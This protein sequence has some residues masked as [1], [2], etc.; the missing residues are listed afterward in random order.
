MVAETVCCPRCHG[1]CASEMNEHKWD[2]GVKLGE[3][4][5]LYSCESCSSAFIYNKV[6][7]CY[8]CH[9]NVSNKSLSTKKGQTIATYPDMCH[10]CGSF[11]PKA[12]FQERK[13]LLH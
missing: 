9:K 6:Y 10:E 8:M 7:W 3:G 13:W 2:L 1:Y 4:E 12:S 11:I 5:K